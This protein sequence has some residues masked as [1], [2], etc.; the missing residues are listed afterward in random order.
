VKLYVCQILPK[1]LRYCQK[2]P[3]N[4]PSRQTK[5]TEMHH[6][7]NDNDVITFQ[8]HFSRYWQ[9][10][11]LSS[12]SHSTSPTPR[13]TSVTT[14][15]RLTTSLSRPSLRTKK[16]ILFTHKLRPTPLPTN[17]VTPNPLHTSLPASSTYM[18]IVVCFVCC[19][20]LLLCGPPP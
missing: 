1:W 3:C 6:N 16:Y 19:F 20:Y 2:T 5:N 10:N 18:Y 13:D 8:D 4:G 9:T 11:I 12:S 17:I 14:R 15:L 7:N